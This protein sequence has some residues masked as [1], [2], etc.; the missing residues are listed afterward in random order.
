MTKAILAGAGIAA[1]AVTSG[2]QARR[3]QRQDALQG[4]GGHK[5]KKPKR[6]VTPLTPIQSSDLYHEDT[7]ALAASISSYRY[8]QPMPGYMT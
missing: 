7:A 8:G 4:S 5:S 1:L 2:N 3:R 6:Q